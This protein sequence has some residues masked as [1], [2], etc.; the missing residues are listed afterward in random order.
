MNRAPP[1]LPGEEEVNSTPCL[2]SVVELAVRSVG[3][4]DVRGVGLPYRREVCWVPLTV[5]LPH[6]LEILGEWF[7]YDAVLVAST[8]TFGCSFWSPS[9]F[10]RL[11]LPVTQSAFGKPIH[12]GVRFMYSLYASPYFSR[13][14]RSSSIT[15]NCHA[16]IH[17]RA[18]SRKTQ[19]AQASPMPM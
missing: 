4:L 5:R 15:P 10:E 16:T 12:L 19:E 6:T 13:Q 2:W 11:A 17:T 18:Q 8:V 1:N 9:Q 14:K 3:H 7:A